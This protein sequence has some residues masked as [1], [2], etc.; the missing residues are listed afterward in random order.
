[1]IVEGFW[2]ISISSRLLSEVDLYL[3][4]SC[5]LWAFD[6]GTQEGLGLRT[7]VHHRTGLWAGQASDS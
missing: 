2:T 5:P 1:M 6:A 3:Y 4:P 7:S